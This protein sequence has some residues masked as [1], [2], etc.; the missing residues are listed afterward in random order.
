MPQLALFDRSDRTLIDD[1][2]GTITYAPG[3]VARAAADAWFATL[4][5][6]LAWQSERRLM[7][8]REVDVPRLLASF[9]LDTLEE[10]APDAAAGR[11]RAVLRAARAAVEAHAGA[12]FDSVGLNHY[13][14]GRDSVAPHNDHLDELEPGAP[15]ALLS[16][17]D[18]RTMTIRSK[19]KPPRVLHVELE[20][21]SV[22]SMSW[23]TQ[24]HWDHGIPKTGTPVGV[25]ISLAFRVRPK[26]GAAGRYA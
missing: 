23:Q 25:R 15:I 21:G 9:R 2:T 7:Y 3:V 14:D 22:L 20:P 13:R 6:D 18:V 16:L 4:R 19:A 10:P 24:H 17:G 26:D 11:V 12:R 8:D 1:T 5:D